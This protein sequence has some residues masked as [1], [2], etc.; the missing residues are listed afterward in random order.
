[1]NNFG[2]GSV[3]YNPYNYFPYTT[4]TPT[5]S[6]S[7]TSTPTYSGQ[8]NNVVIG[9]QGLDAAK[10]YSLPPNTR[11]YFLDVEEDFIYIKEIDPDNIQRKPVRILKCE[12]ITEDQLKAPV[13]ETNVLPSN[14]VTTDIL[15]AYLEKYLNDHQYKPYIP[16]AKK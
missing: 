14:V 12:E 2:S 4:A 8:M 15:D 7:Q 9:V 6:Y 11:G 3:T 10:A 16:R 13:K 1:M 5:P